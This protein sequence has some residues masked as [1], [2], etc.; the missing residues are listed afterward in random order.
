MKLKNIKVINLEGVVCPM[1][2]VK[3]K[4]EIE[5]IKKNNLLKFIYNSEEAKINVPKSLLELG[6]S[7]IEIKDIDEKK[8]HIIIQ[9]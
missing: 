6:H 7:I 5:K 9:K 3:T 4:L 2:F 1:T 8:F